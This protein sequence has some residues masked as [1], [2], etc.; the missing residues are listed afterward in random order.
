MSARP[1][2]SAHKKLARDLSIMWINTA[3]NK[4]VHNTALN[5]AAEQEADVVCVQEPWTNTGKTTQTNPFYQLYAPVDGWIWPKG[6]DEKKEEV[7]PKV[8][9]YSTFGKQ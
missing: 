7:R 8:L 4:D 1:S 9:T 3:R 2:Q 5:L 6:D